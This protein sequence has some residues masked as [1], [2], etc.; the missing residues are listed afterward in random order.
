M[1]T[2]PVMLDRFRVGGKAPVMATRVT[3]DRIVITRSVALADAALWPVWAKS[4][5]DPA[6]LFAEHIRANK[7]SGVAASLARAS[8][9]VPGAS[10]LLRKGLEKDYEENLY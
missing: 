9:A 2:D 6:K 8:L 1:T 3:L 5:V 10:H 4:D 7:A